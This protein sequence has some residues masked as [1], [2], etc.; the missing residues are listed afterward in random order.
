MQRWM[1]SAT[2]AAV[3]TACGQVEVPNGEPK[4]KTEA[5]VSE[6][7]FE[8]PSVTEADRT[9]RAAPYVLAN[10][11]LGAQIA[12]DGAFVALS[13]SK[14]GER[15]LY[16]MQPDGSSLEQVTDGAGISF[17]DI[18]P[19]GDILY[20][21]DND[22]DERENYF[23]YDVSTKSS[24]LIL[25]A[26]EKGFRSYGASNGKQIAYASTERNGLDFDIYLM[27]LKNGEP[28]MVY[29]GR[30]GN[31]VEAIDPG[32]GNLI[33]SETVGE[34]ADKLFALDVKSGERR[35]LSDPTPRA[36]HTDA[37]IFVGE[38]GFVLMAS[39]KGQEFAS[40]QSALS[41]PRYNL[42]PVN[43]GHTGADIDSIACFRSSSSALY[44]VN[45]DGYSDLYE[46]GNDEPLKG[47]PR[48]VYRADCGGKKMVVHVS[49]PDIPGDIFIS[50]DEGG[51]D[52]IYTSDYGTLDKASLVAPDSIRMPARDGVDV[53]G[54]LYMPTTSDTSKPPVVFMVH[55]GPT[56]QARPRYNATVQYLVSRGI[57]V[58]QTNVRGSTG[59]GRTYTTLDDRRKR[60]DSIRDLVDML[61]SSELAAR[62][63]TERAAVMG[64]SYGGYAVNAVLSEYP[65]A[66]VAGVSLYGVADWVTALEVASPALKAADLIEYGNI[67]DPEWREFYT[68][69]SPIRNAD[70][71]KVPVLFSHGAMDPRIDIAETETMVRALRANG[72]DAPFIRMPDEGHG[73]RKLDNQLYYQRRQAE[74]LEEVLGI[75]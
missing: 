10:G 69:E 55:G 61:E 28:Q 21:S 50:N 4:G 59:F 19:S 70:K 1:L 8:S 5:P 47:L 13:S 44:T 58:F 49:G 73:W 57:A 6:V 65:D 14:S 2:M 16:V 12:P 62:V 36:N 9:S 67:E 75:E 39:N 45:R 23:L 52:R 64:G 31:F 48:G 24:R 22:G 66:F 46:R 54:L 63:D 7:A 29:E 17:F 51:F 53:Q 27:D 43:E 18:L 71:I 35:V 15:Q 38:K 30:Y 34:D 26:T 37:G 68:K 56:A 3:L 74:F 42:V 40:L 60:L 41:D 32:T 72:I 33:I 20:G 25:P 11:A